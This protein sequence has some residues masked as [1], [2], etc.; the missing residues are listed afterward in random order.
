[1]RSANSIIIIGSIVVV[2]AA[3][4]ATVLWPTYTMGRA[5]SE[6]WRPTRELEE[7]GRQRFIADGCVYC[8]SQYVRPQDWGLGAERI[9]QAGDYHGQRPQLL[10]SER[11]GPDLS[12]EGGEHPDDW[13]LAHFIDPRFTS[14]RSLM[15]RFEFE[16]PGSV[17]ALTAYVQSLGA[18]DA[19]ARV[20]VQQLWKARALAAFAKGTDAN[21]EWLHSRVPATWRNMPT[22]SPV[23]RASTMRGEKIYQDYCVGCH[24]PVGDGN[25]PAAPYLDPR[26]VNFT[27]LKRHL[28]QGKYIGGILYYQIM[29]GIT[30]SAM[31]YFKK[32][33]ESA[34]IWDVGNYIEF[35]FINHRD[36]RYPTVGIPA[37][38]E[39]RLA[40]PEVRGKREEGRGRP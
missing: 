40:G 15:P 24:G 7:L 11:T 2:F 4:F 39:G 16:G 38:Y 30:G 34:K 25:G 26:P 28:V 23:T 31:P 3:T 8:H 21:I 1:V 17:R 10:G 35:N 20:A 37:A 27:T 36:D 22:Q 32:H 33:L 29:N 9:A 19:D 14:P 6:I 18:K 13:H 5:P 12:Q